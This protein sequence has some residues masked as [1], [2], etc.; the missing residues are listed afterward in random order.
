MRPRSQPAPGSS[1]PVP[2]VRRLRIFA[3]DP[4]LQTDPLM[5]GV[6]EATVDVPWEIDLDSGPGRRIS[7]GGRRRSGERA[8]MRR[9]ISTIQHLLAEDGSRRRKPIRSS[10]SR[11]SMRSRCDDR[12]FRAGARPQGAVGAAAV[13]VT[14][15]GQRPPTLTSD[16][17]ASIR[18]R[19]AR[20]TPT[21][22]RTK[23]RCCSATSAPRARTAAQTLPGSQVFSCLSHDIVAHETTHALLDGLH[24]PLPGA[25][26]PRRAGVPRGL[27]RHRRAVP[28]LHHAGVAARGRSAQTARRCWTSENLLGQLGRAVRPG[29][30]HA[31]RVAQRDRNGSE[32]R[33]VA[34]AQPKR[35]DYTASDEPHAR[36]AV[37]VAA[38]FA[39]FLTIYRRAQRRP[40]PAR[41]QRH[42]RAARRRDLRTISPTA[43]PAKPP[44]S[45]EHVLNMCIRALDYCPP[46][47]MTFGDYLRALITADRDLVP[48]DDR[49][50]P[51]RLHLRVPRPRHLP[52]QCRASRRGQPPVGA[53]AASAEHQKVLSQAVGTL[54]CNGA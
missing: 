16:G 32:D 39:A 21:T 13:A 28:A 11:W 10:I 12:P 8:A 20:R 34:E 47:D 27:R 37:L 49:R 25:D 24:P 50:L 31:R 54:I 2:S 23:W 3:Y 46:V 53:A 6:N 7:R 18:T 40:G 5:F 42:R 1:I 52:H 36:G 44:R 41:D 29:D 38:V 45:R 35:T 22:A 9:S 51:R 17:C 30:R 33:Q 19:C 26:Q 4:S 48:A 43:W 14:A 15:D